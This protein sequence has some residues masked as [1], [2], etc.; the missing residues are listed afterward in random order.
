SILP[1]RV[2]TP[3]MTIRC[4]ICSRKNCGSH[5]TRWARSPANSP[6]KTCL[7]R[8]SRASASG[9]NGLAFENT[10]F[11]GIPCSQPLTLIFAG[12]L[13][14]DADLI[15]VLENDPGG[16]LH[17]LGEQRHGPL[18]I[19]ADHRF[20]DIVVFRVEMRSVDADR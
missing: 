5:T 10:L 16:E 19:T 15:F 17:M 11:G 4:W 1:W 3:I 18:R 2:P 13:L 7:A 14:E 20:G 9:S 8:S 6:A 12:N